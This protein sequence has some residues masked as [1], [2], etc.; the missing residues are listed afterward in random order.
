MG[1]KTEE[2]LRLVLESIAAEKQCQ[3]RD[4][5]NVL[6]LK[7]GQWYPSRKFYQTT[8]KILFTK[9]IDMDA[10]GKAINDHKF[11]FMVLLPISGRN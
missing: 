3:L 8:Q 10:L 6:F 9:P 4:L 5:G 2:K 11:I 1:K 7:D